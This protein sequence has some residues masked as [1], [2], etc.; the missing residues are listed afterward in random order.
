MGEQTE[1]MWKLLQ[2][3]TRPRN[4]HVTEFSTKFRI[5]TFKWIHPF[6]SC[7][8]SNN[9]I[10]WRTSGKDNLWYQWG[11]FQFLTHLSGP[12]F[13][14]C[15]PTATYYPWG[16]GPEV[17]SLLLC[18]HHIYKAYLYFLPSPSHT[19]FHCR[20]FYPP[21]ICSEVE[22]VLRCLSPP[23]N[24]GIEIIG[25]HRNLFLSNSKCKH[26]NASED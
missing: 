25:T 23:T 6:W 20:D 12:W 7:L 18:Y 26:P 16:S 15:L 21:K 24:K 19:V 8:L 22:A 10:T 2:G 1:I 4:R 5:R 17:Q 9:S 13:L 3:R 11:T 14:N